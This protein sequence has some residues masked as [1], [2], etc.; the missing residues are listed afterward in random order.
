MGYLPIADYG[1]IGDLHTVALVGNNGSLDWLCFPEFDSPSVFAAILDDQKGGFFR[2]N[3]I[4]E[5]DDFTL[6]QMYLPSTNILITRFFSEDGLAE[7]T[8]FMP[9]ESETEQVW[10]HRIIRRV[11]VTHGDFRFRLVCQ[12][13]F[14]YARTKHTAEKTDHGVIFRTKDL[15]L[16]L[17]VDQDNID[18]SIDEEKQAVI[19]EFTLHSNQTLNFVLYRVE[20]DTNSI[21]KITNQEID[22]IFHDTV[23]FWRNWLSRC[24]Y[25]G[26]W[27]E[28]VHR[29]ALVLKLLTYAPTGA[30][31]AAPTTSLPEAVGA[32]RNWDYRY[33]WIRDASFTC[34]ALLSLGFEMEAHRFMGW[35]ADRCKESDPTKGGLQI[36][37]GLD[38]RREL[39]EHIL[40]HLAGYKNSRPVR[41]GNAAYKQLQLDIYGE[42]MDAVYLYNKYGRTISYE[43]WTYLR[44]LMNWL[45][46][47]WQEPDDGLW[48]VR[49]GKQRFVYSRFMTW[50][51]L[52]RAVRLAHHRG[53][54]ADTDLWEKTRSQVYEEVITKGYSEKE[55]C[56]VQYYGSDTVDACNLLMPIVKF[57]GPDD[58]LF[59]STLDKILEEL[60]FD[61]L[62]YRYNLAKGATD[63]LTGREGTFSLCSFWLVEALTLCGRLDEARL[64]LEK[65]FSYANH[66]G[67]YS[68]EIGTSGQML[69][70]YPQA[71]TH[72][73][74]INATLNLDRAIED[75]N[76]LSR[77]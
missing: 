3:P 55:K 50:V 20:P 4:G 77:S 27:R 38:G 15:Q 11:S 72:L 9:I 13:A 47:N 67:L 52:D 70:N 26:R 34:Y 40:D 35:V 21:K 53:L 22:S 10:N 66:L 36:M 39:T 29:S 7:I 71:F 31:V 74:L 46:K 68:E 51:A 33:T 65:M 32:E 59:T 64:K 44:E 18:F 6:K 23:K 12:P 76:K 41:I 62:V 45:C 57:V 2:I 48:E 73:S 5:G 17:T 75:G 14:N 56:F 58:P 54:P 24:T 25:E 8:D 30:I 19:A 28:W 37:Y 63:G 42:L 61:S 60:T 49:S 16:A 43:Q 1:V 69:G